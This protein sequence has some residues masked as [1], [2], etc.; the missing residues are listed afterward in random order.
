MAENRI[1]NMEEFAAVSGLSRP[2]VS[3]YFNDPDSVRPKTRERIEAALREHD[4][5][6]NIFAINQNRR[7]TKNIGIIVPYLSDPVFAENA[8]NLERLVIDAGYRPIVLSSHGNPDW[9]IDNLESLRS[10]K[11]A[12]VL[13]APLGRASRRD[14][15]ATFVEE[16]PTVLFDSNIADL[17][18][19]FVGHN[20]E[21]GTVQITEYLCRTGQPPTFYEMKT[22]ANPNAHRRR[23]TYCAVMERLGHPARLIQVPGEGWDFEEIGYREGLGVLSRGELE[24]NTVLCSND[25][26]AIGFLTAAYELGMTVGIGEGAALRVA[27]HDDHPFSR[28]TCPKLTT[29][30]QDFP[31]IAE[32]SVKTLFSIVES[33]KRP[34]VRETTLLTG[35]LILRD[36]A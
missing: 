2:T 4:Y 29:V 32:R 28:F 13:M 3:K 9:E 8:R 20:N 11:P 27:G 24:T 15:I 25:R 17:G 1:R 23:K 31:Q 12:G 6:P 34:A 19:A 18:E 5:R 35:K 22:P 36:S 21:E 33:G 7:L 14:D 10:L 16:V 26:L 30:A